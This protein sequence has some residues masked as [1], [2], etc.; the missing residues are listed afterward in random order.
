MATLAEYRFLPIQVSTPLKRINADAEDRNSYDVE[1]N[2]ELDEDNTESFVNRCEEIKCFNLMKLLKIDMIKKHVKA[3]DYTAAKTVAEEIKGD[4]SDEA[5]RMISAAVERL[6]LNK[7]EVNLLMKDSSYDIF[8]V[9]SEEQQVIFEYALVL[10]LK[11]YKEE[12]A[13]FIRGITP[14]VVDLLE[15]ILE[16]QFGLNVDDYCIE[17]KGVKNW[18]REKLARA[19]LLPI[20]NKV[21]GGCFKLGPVYSNH[22]SKLICYKSKDAKLSKKVEE[23]TKVESKVRN[24]AAHEIVSVTDEWFRKNANKSAQE[25]FSII[26]FLVVKAGINVTEDQWHSYDKMNETIIRLLE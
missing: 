9:K 1:L 7:D 12:Y 23:I 13:D 8:P 4:L 16:K 20:L 15:I 14:I 22:L 19:G 11:L 18:D 2:W 21:Y 25:I 17:K 5:Y 24:V 6:K 3:Y 10:Q 26:Q